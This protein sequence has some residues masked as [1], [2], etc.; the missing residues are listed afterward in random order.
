[1]RKHVEKLF[2]YSKQ[3]VLRCSNYYMVEVYESIRKLCSDPWAKIC[4]YRFRRTRI[5]EYSE[6]KKKV[7]IQFPWDYSHIMG[8]SAVVKVCDYAEGFLD[9]ANIF[10]YDENYKNIVNVGTFMRQYEKDLVLIVSQPAS[11]GER[12]NPENGTVERFDCLGRCQD[13]SM[14]NLDNG[15][16]FPITIEEKNAFVDLIGPTNILGRIFSSYDR[17]TG[18]GTLN[19]KMRDTMK[20]E[21]EKYRLLTV[22]M[23]NHKRT[24]YK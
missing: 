15:A 7:K 24:K 3:Q 11:G 12:Y 1:M 16:T 19:L 4:D 17:T 14:R 21:L 9:K 5:E 20:R 8:S 2:P 22:K 13:F 6:L 23:N 10:K 18:K